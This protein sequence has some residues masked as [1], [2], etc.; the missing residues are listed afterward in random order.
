MLRKQGD[1]IEAFGKLEDLAQ[2][3]IRGVGSNNSS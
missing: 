2:L 3:I 1:R